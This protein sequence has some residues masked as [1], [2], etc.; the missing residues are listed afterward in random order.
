MVWAGGLLH[1][2]CALWALWL[3]MFMW[4]VTTVYGRGGGGG[5]HS[6][7]QMLCF[8]E[9][10][11]P[12]LIGWVGARPHGT[13]QPFPGKLPMFQAGASSTVGPTACTRK[14]PGIDQL[15]SAAQAQD[16]CVY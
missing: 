12:L 16:S 7:L 4:G 10:I 3:F 11:F 2:Q 8:V 9:C 15:F 6:P 13:G 1:R 5:M 14:R